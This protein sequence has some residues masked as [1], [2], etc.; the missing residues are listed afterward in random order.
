MNA[1]TTIPLEI[2]PQAAELVAYL[3]MQTEF[4]QIVDYVRHNIRGLVKLKVEEVDSCGFDGPPA[5][6][7]MAAIDSSFKPVEVTRAHLND[8]IT[9]T[10]PPQVSE[11]FAIF[12]YYV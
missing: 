11:R 3:G 5:A 1:T 4:E 10:Y 6:W 12:L 8:W 9:A 7:M 2:E